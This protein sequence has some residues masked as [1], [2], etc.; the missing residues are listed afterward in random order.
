[1]AHLVNL[2]ALILR[3]DFEVKTEP[4]Q[5][6]TTATQI[7]STLRAADLE[8]TSWFYPVLRKPDFQRETAN[9][10]PDKVADL[11]QSYVEGDLIP[12]VILW[13][14]PDGNI[15][16]IDGAHR[17]SAL[18]GWVHDDYGDRQ[19][20]QPFFGGFIPPEQ[21]KAA[22]RTRRLVNERVG[23]Y[24]ELKAVAQVPDSAKTPERSRFAKNL[25]VYAISLQWVPGDAPK[26]EHSYFKI[27]QKATL[28]DPTELAMIQA[29]RKPNALAT[30]ALIRGG[31]GHKYWSK[32]AEQT[33][34]EIESIGREVYEALFKPALEMPIKTLDLPVAG[35]GYSAESVKMIF[36]LVNYL[37]GVE[38]PESSKAESKGKL[39]DDPTGEA[40]LRFLKA[41][42][43]TAVRIARHRSGVAWS[44]PGSV[45]LWCNRQIL[46]DS[47]P[48]NNRLC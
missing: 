20:S 16:A 33:I 44:S 14:A 35:R 4:M 39:P 37:N 1:M 26:A 47:I 25:S 12:S 24:A 13:R 36:D 3:E 6:S 23:S 43:R 42:Q 29:R 10:D 41:V 38:E 5:T 15:F 45:L 7:T 46:T 28:I 22:E 30:R 11:I 8:S 2:D 19:I 40:T 31:T 32:F 27:N 9:W 48:G 17:L 34:H 21:E 18:L